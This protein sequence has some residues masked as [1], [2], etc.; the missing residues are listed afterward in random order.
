MS[1]TPDLEGCKV[2]KLTVVKKSRNRNKMAWECLCECGNKTLITTHEI[3]HKK[4]KSCGCASGEFKGKRKHGFCKEKLYKV[5]ADMKGRCNNKND[6]H[7]QW[8]G[9]R[10]IKVCD[11]WKSDYLSFRK[12]AIENGYKNGLSIERI[13][14]NGNYEPSN[15][16][17]ANQSEQCRNRRSNRIITIKG[18]SKILT[19]WCA[20]HN[21][22]VTT[23][24]NRISSGYPQEFW[25]LPPNELMKKKK[26]RG[27]RK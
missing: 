6:N 23:V 10:G 11:E 22:S 20:Q 9:E 1:K 7:Y 3:T 13:D 27:F 12:W 5:W 16:K 25:F 18:E 19:D 17:W 8:Y 15:C 21:L 24:H 26:Y 2:G 14:V 4:R